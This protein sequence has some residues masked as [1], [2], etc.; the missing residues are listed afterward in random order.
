ME[1]TAHF[2]IVEDS[3]TQAQK[4]QFIL[5]EAGYAVEHAENGVKAVESLRRRIP[6]AIISDVMMPEMDGFELC[7]QVRSNPKWQDLPFI[8]LTSLSEFSDIIR[9]LECG[10]DNFIT[11]P[12]EKEY[13]LTR[14]DYI[15]T[16]LRI[17]E[18]G[19]QSGPDVG[20]EIYFR[21]RKHYISSQKM[22]ILDLLF[23]TFDAVMQKNVELER[24]NLELR[25]AQEKIKILHGLIPICANCKKIR[26][27]SGFWEQVEVY[28]RQHSDAVFSHGI[29]PDCLKELY[30]ELADR[31]L[32]GTADK[33]DKWKI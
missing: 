33:G 24:S 3:L 1:A 5:E 21:G 28:I 23:S 6:T 15:L 29:C 17:R 27:D 2:L 19:A 32:D 30:P 11:K 16:N 10:T 12:Y 26:N 25:E 9:G 8:L 18:L 14:I 4:L 7:V 31:I 13:L 22:Q 20:I